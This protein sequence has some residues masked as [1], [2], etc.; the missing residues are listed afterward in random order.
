MTRACMVTGVGTAR[1]NHVAH[2]NKK[3]KRK[4]KANIR[5]KRFWVEDEKRWVRLRVSSRGMRT[6]DKKGIE[7]V[8]ADLRQK[9]Q[10]F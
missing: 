9:G 2:C 4:F 8:L 3:V 1:G 7:T 10:K 5:W 6:I